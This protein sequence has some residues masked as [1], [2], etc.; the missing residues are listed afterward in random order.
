MNTE[1]LR[2]ILVSMK[3]QSDITVDAETMTIINHTFSE[4]E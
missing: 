4:V 3:V 2:S 1:T